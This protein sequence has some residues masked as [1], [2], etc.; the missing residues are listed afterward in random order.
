MLIIKRTLKEALNNFLRNSWL[1][2]ATVSNLLLSLYIVSILFVVTFTA[3]NILKTV[4]NKVNVSVYVNINV[5]EDKI[6]EMKNEMAKIDGIKSVDYISRDKAL[7]EFKSTN[8]D[9][10]RILKSLEEIGE[11]PLPASLIIT[12]K[13]PNDYQ[14]I[15][16]KINNNQALKENID[17]INYEKNKNKD[18]VERLNSIVATIRKVGVIIG[19][20]FAANALLITFN[21]VRITI[22]T[23]RQEIETMR[24]VGASN[25][26]IRLPFVFEGIIYGALASILSMIVLFATLKF[27]APYISSAIPSENLI[28]FYTGN[29][30]SLLGAQLLIGMTI[31]IFSSL[32]AMRKYLKA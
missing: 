2:V 19:I 30:W 1:S 28:G 3:N 7:E 13:N 29:F 11:N 23:H 16:D 31:G 20:I 8:A 26:F 25:A 9:E 32:I 12:A 5:V 21:A 4:Q 6:M 27:A 24:L 10:P 14:G 17:W 22:Y 15:V 18:V